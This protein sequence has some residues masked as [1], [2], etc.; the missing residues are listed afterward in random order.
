M[1]AQVW[2]LGPVVTPVTLTPELRSRAHAMWTRAAARDARAI[3]IAVV[4]ATAAQGVARRQD[5]VFPGAS[6]APVGAAGTRAMS[7]AA[8]AFAA[9]LSARGRAYAPMA[10]LTIAVVSMRNGFRPSVAWTELRNVSMAPRTTARRATRTARGRALSAAS[11]STRLVFPVRHTT[12]ELVRRLRTGPGRSAAWKARRSASIQRANTTAPLAVQ[13][14][15]LP[16]ASA[17]WLSNATLRAP[18]TWTA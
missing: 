15:R 1:G 17:A 14:A 4:R 5:H 7:V 6:R 13:D 18:L 12:A 16:A 11:S 9:T 3:L 2:T 8:A 10:R